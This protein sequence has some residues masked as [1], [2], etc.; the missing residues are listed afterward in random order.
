MKPIYSLNEI[1]GLAAIIVV[2]SHMPRTAAILGGVPGG[3]AVLIFYFL[4]GF[5]TLMSSERSQSYFLTK[6]IIKIIPLYYS[7]T[8]FTYII[9]SIKPEWFNTT[10]ATIPH[11]IKS[12]LFIPY[13]NSNGLVIPILDVGWYLSLEVFYY[14]VFWFSMKVWYQRRVEVCSF[15]LLVLYCI[16]DLYFQDNPIFTSYKYGMITLIIGM[17]SYLLYKFCSKENNEKINSEKKKTGELIL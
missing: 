2:C 15:I 12:L 10:E 7:V 14:L 5:L 11:L 16:G 8:I 1:R 13:I 17:Y 6:R 3:Y 9:V 4:S